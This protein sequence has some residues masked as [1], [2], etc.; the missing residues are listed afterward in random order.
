MGGIEMLVRSLS[1]CVMLFGVG[2]MLHD[3]CSCVV[4]DEPQQNPSDAEPT[5]DWQVPLSSLSTD[6][7]GNQLTLM[8]I[9][10]GDPLAMPPD[11]PRDAAAVAR[12]WCEA[13]FV[14]SMRGLYEHRP[15]LRESLQL[16]HLAAGTP[17][18]LTGGTR[19]ELPRRAMLV[20]FDGEHRLLGWLV[21]VP[22]SQALVG[23]IEDAEEVHMVA[24]RLRDEPGGLGAEVARR[25]IARLD[26]RWAAALDEQW[27]LMGGTTEADASETAEQLRARISLLAA[28]F[29]RAYVKDVALRFG[30]TEKLDRTRLAILEQHPQTRRPWCEAM[31]PF[32]AGVDFELAWRPVIESVWNRHCVSTMDR[33]DELITWWA[34]IPEGQSVVL[35]LRPPLL[36]STKSWPPAPGKDVASRRGLGWDSLQELLETETY[37]DV[38]AHEL[39]HL[40][41]DRQIRAID[42]HHP[43]RVR[44]L[45]F[46]STEKN[47]VLIREG[48]IPGRYVALVKRNR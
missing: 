44:Y 45:Y 41:H 29:R 34:A 33:A 31:I 42:I 40:M 25:S 12:P 43:S 28:V 14:K 36:E 6:A 15:D 13:V 23:L 16:Q 24:E 20:V 22:E 30:L 11:P 2:A 26:R 19:P 35:A 18:I 47:P 17:R 21:G 10:D 32:L 7:H 9:T 8:L 1:I 38:T 46:E 3:V 48:D 37:R 4:A 39:C 27:Q 5:L